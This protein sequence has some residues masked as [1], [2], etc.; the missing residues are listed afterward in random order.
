[1]GPPE[2]TVPTVSELLHAA[3]YTHQPSTKYHGKH[4][5][6]NAAGE[7]VFTG[8]GAQAAAWLAAYVRRLP[9]AV[10]GS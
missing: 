1:M 3:G 5:V 4:D 2:N 9:A 8:D 7:V 6:L 10:T